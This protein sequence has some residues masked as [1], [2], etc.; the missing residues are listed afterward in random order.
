ME[1]SFQEVQLCGRDQHFS[2]GSTSSKSFDVGGTSDD[3]LY[4][5]Y[6]FGSNFSYNIPVSTSGPVTVNL[7]FV[8]PWFG[9]GGPGGTG[10]RV[11][12]VNIENGQG[13]INDLDLNTVVSPGTVLV[14]SFNNINVTGGVLNIS[15]NGEIDNAII[16]AIEVTGNDT[17]GAGEDRPYIVSVHDGT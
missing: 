13:I 9:V 2:G 10:K 5:T 11:F 6:R 1:D 12:D 3:E 15:F 16:S 17:G 7:H 8:E 14:R 4:L